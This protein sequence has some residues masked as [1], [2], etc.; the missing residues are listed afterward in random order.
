MNPFVYP[1]ID[2]I[3]GRCVRL[4]KGQFDRV[5]IFDESPVEIAAR[6]ASDGGRV[7][8]VIDLDGARTGAPV[9]QTVLADIVS[10][11]RHDLQVQWGGGL[12]TTGALETAFAAGAARAIVGSLAVIEPSRVGAWVGKF[13]RDR[14]VVAL[15]VRATDNGGY[16]PAISGWASDTDVDLWQ[17]VD[18]LVDLGVQ[19]ILSTDI[20]CD[21]T[22]AG[23]N[24]QLYR[25]FVARYPGVSV[26]AS[27]GVGREA[28]IALLRDVG[29]DAVVVGRALLDG[30]LNPAT[31]LC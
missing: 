25:S 6:Y 28:D 16:A 14:I 22:G 21:G 13:G 7:L 29:V 17:L 23:P 26:M 15:D 3:A 11:T 2:L 19:H 24:V 30:T 8:H 10:D 4:W 5:T 12:R 1:A 31:V 9:N 27:G 18:E 20:N